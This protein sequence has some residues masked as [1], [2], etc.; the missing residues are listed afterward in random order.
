MTLLAKVSSVQTVVDPGGGSVEWQT[1]AGPIADKLRI[2]TVAPTVGA[3]PA[4]SFAQV[5]V[6][7]LAA[8]DPDPG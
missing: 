5:D 7:D 3:T 6:P 4:H 1:A 8:F 2:G